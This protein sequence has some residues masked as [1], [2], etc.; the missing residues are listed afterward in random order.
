MTDLSGEFV[1]NIT[2][3]NND[4]NLVINSGSS[5]VREDSSA[6]NSQADA[7]S[8]TL[9]SHAG[10]I[11]TL[12]INQA[13]N[14]TNIATNTTTLTTHAGLVTANTNLIEEKDFKNSLGMNSFLRYYS[15]LVDL[16]A[17]VQTSSMVYPPDLN[18][19]AD[20]VS[21]VS[22]QQVTPSGIVANQVTKQDWIKL[23]T[24]CTGNVN[25]NLINAEGLDLLERPMIMGYNELFSNDPSNINGF[26]SKSYTNTTLGQTQDVANTI[27]SQ[28]NCQGQYISNASFF[29]NLAAETGLASV[30][31]PIVTDPSGSY[32][33]SFVLVNDDGVLA[34]IPAGPSFEKIDSA[35]LTWVERFFAW[36]GVSGE[37]PTGGALELTKISNPF[38]AAKVKWIIM[39][40][41]VYKLERLQQYGITKLDARYVA[42]L[43][44]HANGSLSLGS[45]GL[46]D[47]EFPSVAFN[48]QIFKELV[49]TAI[50]VDPSM[51]ETNLYSNGLLILPGI[52][53]LASID[54][55]SGYLPMPASATYD[56]YLFHITAMLAMCHNC[57]VTPEQVTALKNMSMP[58]FTPS[59][60]FVDVLMSLDLT[61]NSELPSELANVGVFQDLWAMLGTTYVVNNGIH[62]GGSTVSLRETPTGQ[63][64]IN[65]YK[66]LYKNL[67]D[68]ADSSTNLLF[69]VNEV[70]SH[71]FITE[72]LTKICSVDDTYR[73]MKTGQQGAFAAPVLNSDQIK[74][75]RILTNSIN[76]RLLSE[77]TTRSSNTKYAFYGTF[78][79]GASGNLAAF[80]AA[81]I[82]TASEVVMA[83]TASCP[84]MS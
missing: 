19:R 35:G 81:A 4:S 47:N 46:K 74:R 29:S 59:A 69:T 2:G 76:Y 6:L 75:L 83:T 28:A 63:A 48:N 25:A 18:N 56:I 12:N 73:T 10:L 45:G 3:D 20:N 49:N 21:N 26:N 54:A 79:G 52:V 72:F 67:L 57:N 77:F 23:Q 58:H 1:V 61:L 70:W 82:G 34:P 71:S 43:M 22:L 50:A 33:F 80:D 15:S 38:L 16:T 44:T 8:V 41:R 39:M 5:Y 24:Y 40:N 65:M 13:T 42:E 64:L 30:F 17:G 36:A 27:A 53:G 7:N 9:A 32:D 62:L 14:T 31:M 51:M 78:K 66:H 11:S 60:E 68:N 84:C 37:G 55:S